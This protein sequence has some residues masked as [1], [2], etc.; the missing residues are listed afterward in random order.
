MAVINYPSIDEQRG[1]LFWLKPSNLWHSRES[2]TRVDKSNERRES[3]R[4]RIGTVTLSKSVDDL[5]STRGKNSSSRYS[6]IILGDTGEGDKSQYSL[7]PLIKALN[8]D[9]M[10][11]NGDVAYPAGR[12]DTS[13]TRASDFHQGFFEPYKNLGIPIWATPG[14]HEYYS[15]GEGDEFFN[16]FCTAL[17]EP[18]W[19]SYGLPFSQTTRQPFPYWEIVDDINHLSLI[20]LD[21]GKEANLDGA[22]SWWQFW[23]SKS[24]DAEQLN[25]LKERLDENDRKQYRTIVLF[26]IP[27]LVNSDTDNDT[28]K[29][30][31]RLIASYSNIEAVITGH[32]HN[33]QFYSEQVWGKFLGD[34]TGNTGANPNMAY[35]VSGSGGASLHRTDFDQSKYSVKVL[36]PSA[37]EW[38]EYAEFAAKV[39]GVI[40]LDRTFVANVYSDMKSAL[41]DA[42]TGRYLSLLHIVVEGGTA[43]C[44]PY[45]IKDIDNLYSPETIVDIGANL[46]PLTDQ[47]VASCKQQQLSFTI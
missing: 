8:A 33:Q 20:G 46:P 18:V 27:S 17:H 26:H 16:L 2:L 14:N 40:R 35:V 28:M 5:L 29:Q 15:P 38:K 22:S 4:T 25:W 43:T 12:F 13:N 37:E 9:F 39:L 45:W 42:D 31:H 23:T 36:F 7:L 47:A 19:H 30:I 6:Y 34:Y 41:F 44:V 32:I 11:I 21:T 10:I 3:W 24:A 1:P